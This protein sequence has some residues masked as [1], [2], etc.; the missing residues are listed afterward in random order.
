MAESIYHHIPHPLDSAMEDATHWCGGT[1]PPTLVEVINATTLRVD[2][3]EKGADVHKRSASLRP[4]SS[5]VET[6]SNGSEVDPYDVAKAATRVARVAIGLS[7]NWK[8]NY[9]TAQEA[10]QSRGSS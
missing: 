3:F 2:L 4:V 6:S 7:P 10:R 1:E 8:S 9:A 5:T